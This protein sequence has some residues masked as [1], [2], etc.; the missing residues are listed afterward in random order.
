MRPRSFKK[1]YMAYKET[2]IAME[3]ALSL[4]VAVAPSPVSYPYPC[5]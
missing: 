3:T 5:L 1:H 4:L 2:E